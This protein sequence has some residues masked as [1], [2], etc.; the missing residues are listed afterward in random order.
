MQTGGFN[1]LGS[2]PAGMTPPLLS[3]TNPTTTQTQTNPFGT[4]QTI[5]TQP[6]LFGSKP[7]A[8]MPGQSIS[9]QP[10]LFGSLLGTTA[11]APASQPSL[12][13]SIAEPIGENLPIFA[14]LPPGPR[15]VVLDQPQQKKKNFFVDR[16]ARSVLP[17]P[18]NYTPSRSDFYGPRFSRTELDTDLSSSLLTG[19]PDA[20]SLNGSSEPDARIDHPTLGSGSGPSIKKIILNKKIE[21]CDLFNKSGSSDSL[22][23]GKITFSP[24]ASLA[25]REAVGPL[26]P[27]TNPSRSSNKL[28]ADPTQN[29]DDTKQLQKG[30]YYT[31]PDIVTLKKTEYASLSSFKGLVVGRVGYGEIQFL[32]AVNLTSI[33]S[34][35]NL[36]GDII[37]FNDKECLVYD[38]TASVFKAP[39]G[40]GL[41]VRARVT[42]ERCW[43]TD[44]AT[45]EP[46]KDPSNPVAIKHL[47]HLKAMKGASFESFNMESGKWTFIIANF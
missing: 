47:K 28:T 40:S 37:Q 23:Y 21:P 36:S 32:E 7:A 11:I 33:P 39:P 34:V 8:S 29:T 12:T 25:V 4:M 15:S 19:K 18:L 1:P 3:G 26:S 9:G 6:S 16:P 30:D 13:A 20:L 2:K 31:K 5:N 42:L 43:A 45:R 27:S 44:K 38:D 41:N 35:D 14:L 46:I 10:G 24:A 17:R 22:R